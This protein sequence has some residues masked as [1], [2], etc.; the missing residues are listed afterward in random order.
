MGLALARIRLVIAVSTAL[1]ILVFFA[2]P[3]DAQHQA[4][5]QEIYQLLASRQY[6]QAEQ[7]AT[8]YLKE[9]PRDCNVN[10]MLG[11]ALR[12]QGKMEP[13]FRAFYTA[14]EACPQSLA[15]LEGAAETAFLLNKPD[16][17]ALVTQV[18]KLRP[19]EETGY[20][21]LGAIDARSGDCAAAVENYAK[22]LTLISHNVPALRQYG[23]C[24]VTLGR[25][26]DAE[27][28]LVQLLALSDSPDNRVAL[29]QVQADARDTTAAL[30]TLQPLLGQDSQNSAAFL[31]A[32]Q[33]AEST[34]DTPKAIKWLRK[35][36]Q[37]DPHNVDAYLAFAEISFNHGSF[38]VGIDFLNL[39]IQQ[40]PSNARLY[41]ARGVLEEQ[42]T[43][44]D[45]AL[46]DFEKA[47]RLDPQLSFA[48]DAM[49]M[50]FDQKHDS[51]A[52]LALFAQQAKLHPDDPLLLYLYAEA[53]SQAPDAN[54]KIIEQAIDAAQRSVKL[55]PTYQP[56]RDLL[57][58]LL[59][60]HNDL[61]EVVTQ[62]EAATKLDPYDDLAIYQELL[63][64]HKLN[65]PDRTAAL[66]KQLQQAK[67][68]NQQPKTKYLLEE[69]PAAPAH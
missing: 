30:T 21:M 8:L 40:L 52:A 35:S 26:A 45:A 11:M 36:I 67:A 16:A 1:S 33:L 28:V 31:L 61:Q 69:A 43:Q 41:L 60:R 5:K 13:S 59:L 15:A 29:A 56:A 46:L 48:E 6:Q 66:V 37:A 44:P 18:V 4:Q 7:A 14:L 54:A 58:I 50:L 64:E 65:H 53:L 34:N 62:A 42:M 2:R 27:P 68:H 3:C 19:Q 9:S 49:G 17:K 51:A 22:A 12:G 39:G 24:L 55:E 23:G 32:A 47:H 20:A 63:A 57:C 25:P 38:K 10:A